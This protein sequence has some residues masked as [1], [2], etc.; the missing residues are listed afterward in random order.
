MHKCLVCCLL[1][2][3]SIYFHCVRSMNTWPDTIYLCTKH[4]SIQLY[5]P[6]SYYIANDSVRIRFNFRLFFIVYTQFTII[7]DD[8]TN[9]GYDAHTVHIIYNIMCLSFG[10]RSSIGV[11]LTA[12]SHW[13]IGDIDG[14]DNSING[15][16]KFEI[17]FLLFVHP[18]DRT[19]QKQNWFFKWKCSH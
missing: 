4:W 14:G 3:L 2:R 16:E 15:I 9:Y 18:I 6:Y 10:R 13:I 17:K 19:R 7:L 5:T 8:S 11:H 1:R 12:H